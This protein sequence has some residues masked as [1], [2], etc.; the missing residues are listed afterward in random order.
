MTMAELDQYIIDEKRLPQDIVGPVFMKFGLA[1]AAVEAIAQDNPDTFVGIID[2]GH[3]IRV[4]GNRRLVLRKTTLEAVLG[5]P[6]R[7]PGEIE[8]IMS[9]FAG[10]I[11]VSGEEIV[12]YLEL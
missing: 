10:R 5:R 1:V 9:A 6:V 3:Y 11:R 7:F 4:V 2:R 12:W 8:V